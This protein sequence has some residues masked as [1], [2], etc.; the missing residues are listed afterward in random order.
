MTVN[1][2]FWASYNTDSPYGLDKIALYRKITIFV[3]RA[4]RTGR[5]S[6]V[7]MNL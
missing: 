5:D 3:N 2:S 1:S 6:P 7:K 4:V